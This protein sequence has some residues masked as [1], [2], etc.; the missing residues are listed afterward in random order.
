[1]RSQR[2]TSRSLARMGGVA[3]LVVAVALAVLVAV[4]PSADFNPLNVAA[5]VAPATAGILALTAPRAGVLTIGAV[6][7]F[8]GI[9][10]GLTAGVGILYVPAFVLLIVSAL[11]A[12]REAQIQTT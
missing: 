2:K 5:M 3:A 10:L 9:F 12:E 11:R 6:L 1:M 7:V 8:V 4:R